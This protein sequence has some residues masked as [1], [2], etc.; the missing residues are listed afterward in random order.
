M[1]YRRSDYAEAADGVLCAKCDEPCVASVTPDGDVLSA[2]CNAPAIWENDG[3]T[4]EAVDLWVHE[5]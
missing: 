4:I 3:E 2:C 1:S 5:D